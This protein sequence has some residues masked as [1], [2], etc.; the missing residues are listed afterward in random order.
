M[1]HAAGEH[2][3]DSLEAAVR[4]VREAADVVLRLVAAEGIEHQEGIEA[5]LQI[6]CQ[7]TRQLDAVAVAVG[8]PGT[9]RSTGRERK[10]VAVVVVFMEPM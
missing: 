4:V 7:H 2:V 3:G 10:V 9:R 8:W 5:T 6:L 1:A